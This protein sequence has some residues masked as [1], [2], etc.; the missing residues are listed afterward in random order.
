MGGIPIH[1]RLSLAKTLAIAVLQYHSTP[2]MRLSWR[3]ED[4]LFFSADNPRKA[5]GIPDLSAPHLNAKVKG[6]DGQLS[7]ALTF[8]VQRLA[9][10]P[11]LFSLGVVL[12]EIAHATSLENM[13]QDG[14]LTNGQEDPY[15]EFFTARRL[16]KLKSTTMGLRYDS[17]VEKL[18]ECIFPN[19]DDL[20]NDELQAAF[21]G[22]IICPLADLEERLRRFHMDD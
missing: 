9:R 1:E 3:D 14:D 17:I 16:A 15:T 22:D 2:W 4:I 20:N 8:P 12:L 13:K 19:A 21:Y 6:P 18:V 7:R 5:Q 11:I 10:N